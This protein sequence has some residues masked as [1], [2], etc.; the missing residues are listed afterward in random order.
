MYRM[1]GN[2]VNLLSERISL[3]NSLSVFGVKSEISGVGGK[4]IVKIQFS[5]EI[6]SISDGFDSFETSNLLYI[7]AK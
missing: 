4:S 1:A 2:V 3:V 6:K 5:L 7:S